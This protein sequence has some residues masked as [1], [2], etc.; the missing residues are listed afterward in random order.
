M[1]LLGLGVAA[2]LVNWLVQF[3]A[4]AEPVLSPILLIFGIVFTVLGLAVIAENE[5]K[6]YRAR[7]SQG[8]HALPPPVEYRRMQ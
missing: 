8:R 7:K 5:I 1:I 2:L 6:D 3:P 4:Q